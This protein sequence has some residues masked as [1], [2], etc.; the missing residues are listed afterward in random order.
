MSQQEAVT[1]W[2]ESAESDWDTA[3]LLF[4]SGKYAHCLFFCHLFLEK[5]LKA[6]IVHQTNEA[7]TAT[8]DVEFLAKKINYPM[9]K[10]IKSQLAEISTFNVEARYD[11]FKQRLYKKATK[12]YTEMYMNHI[13]EM[14]V[15]I[16]NQ[17]PVSQ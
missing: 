16:R 15:W 14:S 12:E 7:P 2:I 11:I 17:L 4:S 13:K 6:V 8:H 1:K 3:K 9:D 10:T 5:L